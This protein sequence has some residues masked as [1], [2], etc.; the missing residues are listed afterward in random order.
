MD[1]LAAGSMLLYGS[2]MLPALRSVS[3]HDRTPQMHTDSACAKTSAYDTELGHERFFQ[4]TFRKPATNSF[5]AGH[6]R[7]C[8]EVLVQPPPLSLTGS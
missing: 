3:W 7:W 8:Q 6:C 2:R 1:G 4:K 5:G